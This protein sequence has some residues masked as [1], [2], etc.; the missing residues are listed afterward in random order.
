MT[1]LVDRVP[2][3]R[4]LGDRVHGDRVPGDRVLG[5]RVLGDRRRPTSAVAA[6]S[7]GVVPPDVP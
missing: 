4:V 5:D 2:G 3:D 7:G 1:R 6:F